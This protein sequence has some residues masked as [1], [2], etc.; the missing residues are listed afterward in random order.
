MPC[1]S[2]HKRK[3]NKR[4]DKKQRLARENKAQKVAEVIESK[5]NEVEHKNPFKA[6]SKEQ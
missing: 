6:I 4:L 1:Y 5:A 3:N 2:I